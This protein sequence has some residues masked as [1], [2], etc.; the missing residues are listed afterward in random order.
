MTSNLIKTGLAG[1]LGLGIASGLSA[2]VL[3]NVSATDDIFLAGQGS[4]PSADAG[5][6]PA[7]QS[8]SPIAGNSYEVQFS[9][10]A[11]PTGSGIT[12]TVTP[13]Q[14]SPGC[15][16]GGADGITAAAPGTNISAPA[17]VTTTLSQIQ[18]SGEAMFL[19][20]V[21]LGA[22]LPATQVTSIGQYGTPGNTIS[23]TAASY[24]PLL[25]QTFFIGDGLT[26]TGTGALQ[27]F[28][29]PTGATQLF[30]GFADSMTGFNGTA[31]AFADNGGSLNVNLQV[32]QFSS[33]APEPGTIGLFALGLGALVL[34]R[35]KLLA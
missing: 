22:G 24:S 30:L 28:I 13:C 9:G 32:V 33:T 18:Y 7:V 12:G 29:V 15:P 1:L 35:K 31:G 17:S 26:G 11:V 16:S 19:V 21:F 34:A 20:G 23:T 3:L 8:F 10:P 14:F 2:S 25:G 27:N 5:A 6:L 4:S